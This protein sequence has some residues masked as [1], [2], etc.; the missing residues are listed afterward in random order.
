MNPIKQKLTFA[1]MRP[2]NGIEQYR[3][4]Y[5][6]HFSCKLPPVDQQQYPT[7]KPRLPLT[8][9]QH[10][11]NPNWMTEAKLQA[12]SQIRSKTWKIK[13]EKQRSKTPKSRENKYRIIE[14]NSALEELPPTSC[15][16]IDLHFWGEIE[17]DPVQKIEFAA[18]PLE[19]L[20]WLASQN[21]N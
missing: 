15:H 6:T 17:R 8:Q 18:N 1:T 12:N 11:K 7:H 3:K 2:T 4:I 5:N 14:L 20:R 19:I 9:N 16:N 21:P 13:W 10:L